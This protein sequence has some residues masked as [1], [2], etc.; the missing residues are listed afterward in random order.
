MRISIR[1]Y[2]AWNQMGDER[3]SP[4]SVW[5]STR[6][7][8]RALRFLAGGGVFNPQEAVWVDAEVPNDDLLKL[9]RAVADT[10]PFI[11][12]EFGC[13]DHSGAVGVTVDAQPTLSGKAEI[14][15]K[16]VRVAVGDQSVGAGL[17]KKNVWKPGGSEFAIGLLDPTWNTMARLPPHAIGVSASGR[18]LA[19][20]VP[21][22]Y[23]VGGCRI[24]YA[25]RT[26][27]N[28]S[29]AAGCT[30]TAAEFRCGPAY[31]SRMLRGRRT[32]GLSR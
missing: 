18:P 9:F 15:G 16:A 27:P 8:F 32:A 4:A 26:L 13:D 20:E 12:L 11:R 7:K 29:W 23:D 21:I 19:C 1:S 22:T 25:P 17:L 10:D 30:T 14:A 24:L 5:N 6:A 31:R 28:S 2:V 3:P